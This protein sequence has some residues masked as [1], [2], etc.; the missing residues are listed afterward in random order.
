MLERQLDVAREEAARYKKAA[1]VWKTRF[2]QEKRARCVRVIMCV[3][4]TTVTSVPIIMAQ[5]SST[6]EMCHQIL[7]SFSSSSSPSLPHS[8]G[9]QRRNRSKASKDSS[10]RHSNSL[11]WMTVKT[12]L[13][14]TQKAVSTTVNGEGAPQRQRR[15]RSTLIPP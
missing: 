6:S 10:T 14:K 8:P 1:R 3:G 4:R 9:W 11:H 15:E 12:T 7:S 13:R 5:H 2:E